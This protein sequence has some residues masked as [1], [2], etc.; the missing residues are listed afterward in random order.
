T[1]RQTEGHGQ[2][3]RAAIAAVAAA[4][5]TGELA[6]G[7]YHDAGADGHEGRGPAD[8][9]TTLLERDDVLTRNAER[10]DGG[11][12]LLRR[13]QVGAPRREHKPVCVRAYVRAV[14]GRA[15]ATEILE[16]PRAPRR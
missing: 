9:Q 10:V 13:R 1:D 4:A 2:E 11:A 8:R 3:G 12:E 7:E 15:A 14:H 6:D 16:Q 5:D